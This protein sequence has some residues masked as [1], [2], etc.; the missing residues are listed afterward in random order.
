VAAALD[1]Q[2]VVQFIT[3]ENIEVRY[4]LA[5]IGSRFVAALIDHLIQLLAILAIYLIASQTSNLLSLSRL[6][7]GSAPFWIQAIAAIVI[8]VIMFGYFVFFELRTG[9]QS[10]GKRVAN[11]RVV[12][13]GGYP[14][15][16]YSSVIRNLVR[17]VD[18]ALP[19]PY[20]AGMLSIFVSRDYKRLGDFAA[21]TIVIKERPATPPAELGPPRPIV[22]Q[23][24][25][26]IRDVEQLTPDEYDAVRRYVERRNELPYPLQIDFAMRLALPLMSRLGITVAIADQSHYPELLEAIDRRYRDEK[27]ISSWQP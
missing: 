4:E 13:D 25:P 11:L 20:G 19:P 10:P 18:L 15:D 3:P 16:P 2:R 21:G 6:F 12:R 7:G 24:M 23:L 8:F 27:G 5:G 9:G 14:I 22:A 26:L 17:I 1:N